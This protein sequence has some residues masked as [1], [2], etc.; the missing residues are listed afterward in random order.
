MT[1]TPFHD[2]TSSPEPLD[3]RTSATK[4]Q[5]ILDAC[6]STGIT[7]ALEEALQTTYENPSFADV[8]SR[9]LPSLLQ[10][11]TLNG[12]IPTLTSLRTWQINLPRPLAPDELGMVAKAV[13]HAARENT[14]DVNLRHDLDR[15]FHWWLDGVGVDQELATTNI[16]LTW[17]VSLYNLDALSSVL[18][19]LT[20]QRLDTLIL[21]PGMSKVLAKALA[22]TAGR[23]TFLEIYEMIRQRTSHPQQV[24]QIMHPYIP[25]ILLHVS[26]TNNLHTLTYFLHHTYLFQPPPDPPQSSQPPSQTLRPILPLP[27]TTLPTSLLSPPLESSFRHHHLSTSYLLRS[28][29]APVYFSKPSEL[30]KR[31]SGA[32]QDHI[33]RAANVLLDDAWNVLQY[34]GR[35]EIKEVFEEV[36]EELDWVEYEVGRRVEGVKRGLAVGDRGVDGGED[37][38]WEEDYQC[39]QPLPGDG[40]VD[41]QGGLVEDGDENERGEDQQAGMGGEAGD[42]L[43]DVARRA[44]L[45]ETGG[46]EDDEDECDGGEPA[47]LPDEAAGWHGEVVATTAHEDGQA[48]GNGKERA[49]CDTGPV[50]RLF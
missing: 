41:W 5:I 35:V 17:A 19:K 40:A 27:F 23:S 14:G 44:L 29:G 12:D 4:F 8:V 26:S 50:E 33:R 36:R 32:R 45:V 6:C 11:A 18:H 48:E 34:T 39:Q 37:G 24:D 16:L 20:P 43:G 30:W 7:K 25:D 9:R 49:W 21:R 22:A 42:W 15:S 13:R 47:G 1:T 3:G 10:V 31:V 38:E 2:R 46:E 28:S